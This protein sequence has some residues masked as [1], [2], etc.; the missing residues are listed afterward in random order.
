MTGL[1]QALLSSYICACPEMCA[2][3]DVMLWHSDR[4]IVPHLACTTAGQGVL[5]G[6]TIWIFI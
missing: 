4:D 5:S 2:I 6:S 3:T 1:S